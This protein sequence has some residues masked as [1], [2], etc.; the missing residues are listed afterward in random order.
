SNLFRNVPFLISLELSLFF[1]FAVVVGVLAGAKP[2]AAVCSARLGRSGDGHPNECRYRRAIQL[3]QLHSLFIA[4]PPW[5]FLRR[6]NFY[7][8]GWLAARLA[9][10]SL[11]YLRSHYQIF[12]LH[13]FPAIVHFYR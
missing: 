5:M 3:L 4:L 9:R 10:C 8:L 12:I 7:F 13:S 6:L 2:C 1:S 11:D